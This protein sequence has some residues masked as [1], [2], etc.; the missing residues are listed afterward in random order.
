[1]SLVT[2]APSGL[3]TPLLTDPAFIEK[4]DI[5]VIMDLCVC[6]CVCVCVLI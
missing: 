6:V 3:M 5:L 1:M 2:Q 4:F